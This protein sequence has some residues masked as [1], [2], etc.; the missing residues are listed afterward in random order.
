VRGGNTS[1]C[2]QAIE[3][4]EPRNDDCLIG[5][6]DYVERHWDRNFTKSKYVIGAEKKD[7]NVGVLCATRCFVCKSLLFCVQLVA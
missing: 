1:D 3:Q 2:E 4:L 6:W 5:G 7:S